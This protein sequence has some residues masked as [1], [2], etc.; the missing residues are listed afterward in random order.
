M[1]PVRV[2]VPA[3]IVVEAA[4]LDAGVSCEHGWLLDAGL[5]DDTVAAEVDVQGSS[6]ETMDAALMGARW[7]KTRSDMQP[8][9][10]TST[11]WRQ[12]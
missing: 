9:T 3:G 10:K 6:D 12:N 11:I 4:S 8:R 2:D 5:D 7:T 1:T